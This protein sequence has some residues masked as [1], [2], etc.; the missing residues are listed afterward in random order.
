M[1][2]GSES[3]C[4]VGPIVFPEIQR[5]KWVITVSYI[6]E[7]YKQDSKKVKINNISSKAVR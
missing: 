4:I 7:N 1:E 5:R 3:G 6:I 2:G